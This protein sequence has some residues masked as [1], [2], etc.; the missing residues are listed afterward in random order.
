MIQIAGAPLFFTVARD[1]SRIES[2]DRVSNARP[3][4]LTDLVFRRSGLQA[5]LVGIRSRIADILIAIGLGKEQAETDAARYFGCC[6][7]ESFGSG[8]RRA[9]IGHVFKWR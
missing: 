1:Q 2:G 9:K 8:N 4:L 3:F 5:S 6:L 7:I